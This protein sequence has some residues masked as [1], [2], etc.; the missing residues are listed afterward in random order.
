MIFVDFSS[1]EF[2][3]ASHSTHM[4]EREKILMWFPFGG[5]NITCDWELGDLLSPHSCDVVDISPFSFF[6]AEWIECVLRWGE[7]K[8]GVWKIHKIVYM[9]VPSSTKYG[10]LVVSSLLCSYSRMINSHAFPVI[11]FLSSSLVSFCYLDSWHDALWFG[12]AASSF[13]EFIILWCSML[14]LSLSVVDGL[15]GEMR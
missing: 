2:Y 5:L 8:E 4:R 1:Y 9:E 10:C 11:S 13:R 6:P 15:M 7:K 14:S 3:E 12:R